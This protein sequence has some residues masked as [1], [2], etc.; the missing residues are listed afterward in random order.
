MRSAL[1]SEVSHR[2]TLHQ[3]ENVQIT[4]TLSTK[5]SYPRFE[6]NT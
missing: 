5:S 2:A 4:G 3:F 6:Y 1:S